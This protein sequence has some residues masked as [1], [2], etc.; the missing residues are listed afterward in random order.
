MEYKYFIEFLGTI[1]LV[2]AHFLTHANPYAMGIATFA[3]YSIGSPVHAEHFSPLMTTVSYLL[4]RLPQSE[5][6]Y[7]IIS[8][9]LA[10][11]LVFVTFKGFHGLNI[12]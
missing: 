2:F 7:I 6:F 4:G 3:V 5:T 9:F 12:D 1:V 11:F 8:Q 10:A